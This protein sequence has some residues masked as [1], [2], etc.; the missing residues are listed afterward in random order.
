MA[1]RTGTA[2]LQA[3][4]CVEKC[5]GLKRLA[6]TSG[7]KRAAPG[8]L[9]SLRAFSLFRQ[10]ETNLAVSKLYFHLLSPAAGE[11]VSTGLCAG[12]IL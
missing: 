11:G 12:W 8:A 5:A 4:G 1:A 7:T 10:L 2:R 6:T 3:M 9:I